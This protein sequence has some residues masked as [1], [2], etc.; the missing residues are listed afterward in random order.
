MSGIKTK[1]GRKLT[2]NKKYVPPSVAGTNGA[3]RAPSKRIPKNDRP[4]IEKN[5]NIHTQ[6]SVRPCQA[7][8]K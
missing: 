4:M 1:I 8:S 5:P 7:E 2:N 6:I 3:V